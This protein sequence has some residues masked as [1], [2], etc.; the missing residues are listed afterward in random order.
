MVRIVAGI[1]QCIEF[2]EPEQNYTVLLHASVDIVDDSVGSS[3][4]ENDINS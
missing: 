2:Q 3:I 4:H 1:I